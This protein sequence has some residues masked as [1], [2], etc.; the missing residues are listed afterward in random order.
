VSR[1]LSAVARA[2]ATIEERA[3]LSEMCHKMR[4]AVYGEPQGDL[5]SM[6]EL[7]QQRAQIKVCPTCGRELP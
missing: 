5:M 4:H 3:I 2:R 1:V 6:S 7:E